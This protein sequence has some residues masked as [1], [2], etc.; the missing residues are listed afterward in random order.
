MADRIENNLPAQSDAAYVRALDNSG[1]PIR[2]SKA[3]LAQVVAELIPIFPFKGTIPKGTDINT[4]TGI[5][6][7]DL[8]GAYV[9]AP[10]TTSWGQLVVLGKVNKSQFITQLTSTDFHGFMRENTDVNEWTQIF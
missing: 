5:G 2:I 9:N 3:D 6:V 1:N 10:F 7:Y 8:M 4:V